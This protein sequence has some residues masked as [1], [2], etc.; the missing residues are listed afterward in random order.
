MKTSIGTNE[1]LILTVL[2]CR[3]SLSVA[4]VAARLGNA[5]LGRR[6]DDGSIY[7]ALHRMSQRGLVTVLKRP[8]VSADGRTRQ[9]GYYTIAAAGQTAASRF[10]AESNAVVRLARLE[11]VLKPGLQVGA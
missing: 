4:D 3:E 5:D 6:I 1:A 7:L 10:V 2:Q 9:I 8:V 11:G